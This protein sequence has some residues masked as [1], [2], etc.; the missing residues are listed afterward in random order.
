MALLTATLAN[1]YTQSTFRV[2]GRH[3][4]DP[5]GEEL[6][7]RG[8]NEMFIW[9]D[10]YTG[11][12]TMPEI[13]KTGANTVRIVWLTEGEH[14][15]AT[16]ANLDRVI[17]N[18]ID[19]R[20]FPMPELHGATGKLEKVPEQVD[21]WTRPDVVEVLLKH[22]QYLLLNIANEAGDH[23]VQAPAFKTTYT[24]AIKRIRATGLRSPLI[25]DASGWGQDINILQETGPYL[26][27]QDPERN[28][29]FSV[30]TWWV[31]NDGSAQRIIDELRESVE[32]GLPLIV[33]EFAPMGT[34]CR[35]WIDYKTLMEECQKHGI[36]WLA[37]SWG[38]APNGDCAEMDMTG[39]EHR[40]LFRGLHGWGEEVAVSSP[41]SIRNT[42]K[43]SYFLMNGGCR[44]E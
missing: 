24:D 12:T 21:Y 26:I 41:F 8:V 35:R 29:I 16:A 7:M 14:E 20:M 39:G 11:H 1:G 13:A 42:S 5:C 22:Q 3:I 32:M 18:A 28:L 44:E 15:N 37:W 19:N 17:Q 23:S 4:L 9:N 34:Q 38:L 36:G 27:E 43:R 10:D 40:G 2:N 6:I 30:H 33:G 31:A 25:I